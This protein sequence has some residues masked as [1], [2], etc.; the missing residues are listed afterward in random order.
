VHGRD[1]VLAERVNG[2]LLRTFDVP[3]CNVP[4]YDSPV[5]AARDALY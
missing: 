4:H 2:R 5:G 3:N 1:A